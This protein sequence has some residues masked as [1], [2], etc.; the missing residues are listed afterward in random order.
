M[1]RKSVG[2]LSFIVILYGSQAFAV[3]GVIEINQVRAQAGGVTPADTAGFPV[4]LSQPGS[5][6]LTGNLN[7]DQETAIVVS[8]DNVSIDL[9]G[10]SIIGTTVCSGTN[11]EVSCTPTSFT[12]GISSNHDNIIVR[13]GSIIGM[14]DSGVSL[15]GQN[16]L[17]E[18][19]HATSNGGDGIFAGWTCVVSRSTARIN[20]GDGI[21][22]S[23]N[24]TIDKNAATNNDGTGR[25]CGPSL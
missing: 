19:I 18:N 21:E 13:N 25:C 11:S 22:T 2:L 4:T 1:T 15:W 5:Y 10:F 23:D 16:T 17:V 3:D 20:G 12:Q 24:C 14:G 7:V 8:S 9:N 6:R